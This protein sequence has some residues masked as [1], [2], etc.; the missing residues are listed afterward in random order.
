MTETPEFPIDKKQEFEKVRTPEELLS[1]MV[2]NVRYGFIGRN[3]KVYADDNVEINSEM[4][5]E[6]SLQSP[7]ELLESGYGICW[8]TVELE[9]RWFKEHGYKPE[10]YFMLYAM[11]GGTTLPTHTF[12]V[13]KNNDKWYW[14]EQAFADQ[15]GI[16]E[17]ANMEELIDD[18]KKKHHHYALQHWGATNEDFGRLRVAPYTQPDYVSNPQEYMAHILKENQQLI[19]K[20]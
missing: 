1:F 16:H 3:K 11:E 5:T 8:D 10:T 6:Y 9:R 15:R 7:E 14:F 20:G 19:S 17:Y 13:F 18:V 2:Q 12:I 4:E